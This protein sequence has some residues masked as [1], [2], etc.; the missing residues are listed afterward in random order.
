MADEP[1]AATV[2]AE[3]A[4][5]M[6]FEP[7]AIVGQACM[8]PGALTPRRALGERPRR[9]R[10]RSRAAPEDRWGLPRALAMG[11]STDALGPDLVRRGG[12]VTGFEP[13]SIRAASRI[14]ADE[15]RA[16]STRCSSWVLA[17]RARGAARR[18][19]APARR[20]GLVLGNLSFPSSA[21]A[22]YAESVWLDA[23]GARYAG[24]RARRAPA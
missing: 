7:I 18:D 2:L 21:M 23:Q 11:A 12:Y 5:D 24:G 9:A 16:R 20:T 10:A 13:A 8:L 17:R 4:D 6:D 14:D 3:R 19:D 22:R 15:H 1:V